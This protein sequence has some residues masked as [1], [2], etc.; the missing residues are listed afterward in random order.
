MTEFEV[1][2]SNVSRIL[3]TAGFET[4]PFL[5]GWYNQ[6]VEKPFVL[7]YEDDTLAFVVISTPAM[8]D[9]AFKPFIC[10][11]S[12]DEQRD[13]ID[14]CMIHYFN[15]IKEA[16]PDEEVDTM[17]DFEMTAT[18]RPKVLVQT[19][20]HVAGAAHYYQRKDVADDPWEPQQKICGVSVHPKYGGWFALRG[21]A[22]FKSIR[23]PTLPCVSPVDCV[24]GREDRIKLL[25]KF[26]FHW[27]DWTYR[28]IVQVEEKYSQEQMK[29]FETMPKDRKDIV[30]EIKKS[31]KGQ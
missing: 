22:V 1:V 17:H 7:P 14:E 26:N 23:Q 4:Y 3:N 8:F 27:K 9:K 21:V 31:C 10:R 24:P 2:Q 30:E 12:C 20:G 5:I 29:Y 15:R 28:D 18:R 16:F 11:Q 13:P 25:E 19:A 6:N